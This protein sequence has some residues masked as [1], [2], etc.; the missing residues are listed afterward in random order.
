MPQYTPILKTASRV[1][2]AIAER[3]QP[4]DE[5]V[6]ELLRFAPDYANDPLDVLA[7]YVVELAMDLRRLQER[8]NAAD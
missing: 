2:M 1:L 5:D 3:Q 8:S 6:A 7:C 4:C